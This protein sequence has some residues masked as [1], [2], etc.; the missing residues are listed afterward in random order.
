M[1]LY[2]VVKTEE[3]VDY[4]DEWEPVAAFKGKADL[5]RKIADSCGLY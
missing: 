3:W 4:E 1:D 5:H 2:C